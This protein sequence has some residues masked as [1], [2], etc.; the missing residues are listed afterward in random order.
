MSN[1]DDKGN[2]RTLAEQRFFA[3]SGT[4]SLSDHAA[5]TQDTPAPAPTTPTDIQADPPTQDT[6]QAAPQETA[7]EPPQETPADQ[8]QV[9]GGDDPFLES[10]KEFSTEIPDEPKPEESV[11]IPEG[12]LPPESPQW[13]KD[14][15]SRLMQDETLTEEDKET[16][17]QLNPK[18]WDKARKWNKD[19]KLLGQFRN[20]EV[21][22]TSVY[23]VLE[24]QSPERLR[25]L[26]V[27]SINRAI[28]DG[29][30]LVR[31][32]QEH[33][34]VFSELL[35]SLIDNHSEFVTSV[36][37]KKGY[38][39]AKTG[40]V[41]AD[42][43]LDQLKADP[44]WETLEDT[45][46]GDKLKAEIQALAEKA[47]SVSTEDLEKE[48]SSSAQDSDAA[49]QYQKVYTTVQ[50]ARDDHWLKAVA[51]GLHNQGIRPATQEETRRD[52]A[53]ASVK[54]LIYHAALRGL[55]GVLPNWDDH[56][57][58]WGA[59]QPGFTTTMAELQD[60]LQSGNTD[61]FLEG[62][63][64]L[65]PFYYEFGTKRAM[66]P[67]IRNTYQKVES[68][69]NSRSPAPPPKQTQ[70][71]STASNDQTPTGRQY[72]TLAEKRFFEKTA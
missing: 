5:P 15:Y 71:P 34:K 62:A 48:L 60:Q 10:L 23:E 45:E 58:K 21:P 2:F 9:E 13:Q 4:P 36:L 64:A 65:N 41:S 57:S 63:A 33:P 1:Q 67:F 6:P 46:F 20:K 39:V 47:S 43:I 72:R 22:I 69:L 59:S 37:N 19:T 56:S 40:P 61:K 53:L 30:T 27:E 14:A 28:G 68:L 29:E 11:D 18:A 70:P 25:E 8:V 54:N 17:K 35:V 3:N 26:E 7:Q 44:L 66:I 24:K 50:K 38:S 49:E 32:S 12:V 16:I 31:F 55:D 52:P 42:S 51:D